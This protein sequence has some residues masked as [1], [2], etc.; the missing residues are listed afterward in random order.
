MR[1]QRQVDATSLMAF[2]SELSEQTLF[3][4]F[5]IALP[6][7]PPSIFERLCDVDGNRH[8]GI[9]ALDSNG[10][11]IAEARYIRDQ[12]SETSAEFA[13]SIAEG[14]RGIGLATSMMKEIETE[15]QKNG[16]ETLW[17]DVLAENASML[18]LAR[19]LGYQI[20]RNPHDPCC[21]LL[22]KRLSSVQ[23]MKE[24]A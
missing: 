9:V 5:M 13:L 8:V 18:A 15:A 20:S 12:D 3:S 11:L 1:K 7:V 23:E 10:N 17:A 16:I 19:K 22:R 21:K 14:W 24:A 6:T 2:F 4:R